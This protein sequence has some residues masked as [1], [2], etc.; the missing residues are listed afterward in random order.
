[1]TRNRI[2]V[3]LLSVVLL[4]ALVMAGQAETTGTDS[5]KAPAKEKSAKTPKVKP[6][7]PEVVEKSGIIEVKPAAD[8]KMEEVWLKAEGKTFRLLPGK[9]DQVWEKAKSLAGKNVNLKG[10]LL[11]AEGSSVEVAIRLQTVKDPNAPK[12]EKPKSEIVF[13]TVKVGAPAKDTGKKKHFTEIQLVTAAETFRLVPGK[14]KE[15]FQALETMDGQVASVK[16]PILDKNEKF[17]LRALRV[18][19]SWPGQG[20]EPKKAKKS[21][22]DKESGKK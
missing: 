22:E 14:K 5:A 10:H 19:K 9:K 15:A 3:M 17:P 13:G 16:G 11:P 20:A 7:K 21:K 4:F 1:M 18:Q 2:W 6:P 8:G 12:K